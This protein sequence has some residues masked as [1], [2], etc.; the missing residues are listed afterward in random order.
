MVVGHRVAPLRLSQQRPI[1]SDRL[2]DEVVGRALRAEGLTGRELPS[3]AAPA[4]RSGLDQRPAGVETRVSSCTKR[5]AAG[6]T[7]D[8][9]GLL[10]GA[11]PDRSRASQECRPGV[12]LEQIDAAD[13]AAQ[14]IHGSMA[15]GFHHLED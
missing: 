15:A 3:A 14:R 6:D 2:R 1:G 12:F 11:H 8:V 9:L 5:R 4:G 7:S 13:I 10:L